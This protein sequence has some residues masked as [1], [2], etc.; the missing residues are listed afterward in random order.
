MAGDIDYVRYLSMQK[1][2]EVQVYKLFPMSSD[3]VAIKTFVESD[4][5]LVNYMYI[6]E[7]CMPMMPWVYRFCLSICFKFT[8]I[9]ISQQTLIRKHLHLGH[10]YLGGPIVLSFHLFWPQGSCPGVGLE[11]NNCD[12]FSKC[13]AF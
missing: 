13:S 8:Y 5:L 3:Y 6:D 7:Q 12:T 10:G 2:K 9:G 11:V 1:D 4:P